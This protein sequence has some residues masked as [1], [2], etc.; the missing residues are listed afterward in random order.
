MSLTRPP[1]APLN[2]QKKTAHEKIFTAVIVRKTPS[3]T[4]FFLPRSASDGLADYRTMMNYVRQRHLTVGLRQQEKFFADLNALAPLPQKYRPLSPDSMIIIFDLTCALSGCIL[5]ALGGATKQDSFSIFGVE[6]NRNV[7][8][9]LYVN[10]IQNVFYAHCLA[11]AIENFKRENKLL[12][13]WSITLGIV[14]SFPPTAAMFRMA[15]T[16]DYPF[17]ATL[18]LTTVQFLG[19]FP[20]S[21]FGMYEATKRVMSRYADNP[22]VRQFL[23]KQIRELIDS[24][25]KTRGARNAEVFPA[26]KTLLRLK[27][28]TLL[29][30]FGLVIGAV[31]A[32][33]QL[34]SVISWVCDGEHYLRD[35]VSL[36]SG[37][38]WVLSGLVFNLPSE[39]IAVSFS[40]F[41]VGTLLADQ[42][43]EI[44]HYCQ[45]GAD[46]HITRREIGFELLFYFLTSINLYAAMY[47]SQTAVA[48]Y[49][50]CPSFGI[51]QDP[52]KMNID[53]A[54]MFFNFIMTQLACAAILQYVARGYVNPARTTEVARHQTRRAC[55]WLRSESASVLVNVAERYFPESEDEWQKPQPRQNPLQYQRFAS[56]SSWFSPLH[57]HSAQPNSLSTPLLAISSPSSSDSESLQNVSDN[58]YSTTI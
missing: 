19:T 6:V 9:S 30:R 35:N 1:T 14:S 13:L 51:L 4:R 57:F 34:A 21:F 58:E 26:L 2:R 38:S 45:F 40:G 48:L 50:E 24:D 29:N 17:A 49:E 20:L 43:T 27:D 15:N 56:L 8:G 7:V 44:Y 5:Y 25:H 12:L 31:L 10:F 46:R 28:N 18:L 47:S 42:A 22:R 33:S 11:G 16:E 55:E 3:S 54:T 41:D 52:L 37:L 36:P 32:I 23:L 39:L 53:Y